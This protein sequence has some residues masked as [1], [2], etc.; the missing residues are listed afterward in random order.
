MNQTPIVLIHGLWNSPRLFRQ[1][2]NYVDCDCY[3][4][5]IPHLRHDLGKKRIHSLA[6]QLDSQ[7][8]REF[9]PKTN[10]DIVGFSMGG[11]ISRVWLQKLGGASRTNRFIS[12]GTPHH[13]TY[14][15]QLIPSCLFPGIADMKRGSD[16]V[17]DLNS[18][19]KTLK[20]IE[21]IVFFSKWDLMSFPG[22][23]GVLTIG[24]SISLPV[25]THK[26]LI[27]HSKALDVLAKTI[28][29]N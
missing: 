11:L 4:I 22:G 23:Q 26:Q 29:M 15:A 12:I 14:T 25:L 24:R 16:L 13:G 28:F 3:H 27:T 9:G 20:D 8:N 19:L 1:L 2:I 7:I 17:L 21:C 10:I 18:E 5:F 6:V